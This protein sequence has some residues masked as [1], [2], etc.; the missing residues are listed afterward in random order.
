MTSNSSVRE[1]LSKTNKNI[2]PKDFIENF[3]ATSFMI[4]PKWKQP[5][6]PL[7]GE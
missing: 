4:A 6:C 1:N 5:K 3:T 7:T 2:C